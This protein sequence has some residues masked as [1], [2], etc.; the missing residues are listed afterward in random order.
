MP[1]S[2]PV[3][4]TCATC[5][6]ALADDQRYCLGCGRPSSP[7]RLAFLDAL[8][9][10]YEP[11]TQVAPV[12]YPP[13]GYPPA[14]YALPAEP[15]GAVGWLHRYS[16]VL[17]LFSAVLVTALI[18]LLV[19]HWLAPSGGPSKQVL[20]LKGLPATLG[21]VPATSATGASG[22]PSS[23]S[24]I[25]ATE[26]KISKSEEVKEVK[27]AE[28]PTAKP[29]SPVKTSSSGLKKLSKLKGRKYQQALNKLV[30]GDQPIQTGG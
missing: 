30:K 2:A 3:P 21:A 14:G 18:G 23:S 17:A 15:E 20:E 5:G 16:G 28:A 13:A 1:G 8:Q 7:T 22:Q 10:P 19:G 25:K 29:P 24:S 6:A 9:G 4:A 11:G 26:P 12:R 27:E